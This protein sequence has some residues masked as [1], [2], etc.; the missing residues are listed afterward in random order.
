MA[1]SPLITSPE[2]KED[3]MARPKTATAKYSGAPKDIAAFA[4]NGAIV[5]RT[6][7]LNI[8]PIKEAIVAIS[9]ALLDSPFAVRAGPS[10]MVAA[11]ATVPGVPTKIAVMHPP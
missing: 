7:E 8:P 10:S 5:T 6:K 11:A 3:T 9:R 1:I 2:D 4:S